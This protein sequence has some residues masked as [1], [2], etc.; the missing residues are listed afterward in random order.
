[1]PNNLSQLVIRVATVPRTDLLHNRPAWSNP[2]LD[3]VRLF[4]MISRNRFAS[5]AYGDLPYT[6][7]LSEQRHKNKERIGL[8]NDGG[9]VLRKYE[10]SQTLT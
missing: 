6:V 3:S 8:S 9:P 5:I 7:R 1:M 2:T 4:D 10:S